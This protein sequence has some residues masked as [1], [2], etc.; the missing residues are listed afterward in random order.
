MNEASEQ[1]S[2]FSTACLAIGFLGLIV[3]ML[4]SPLGGLSSAVRQ[5]AMALLWSGLGGLLVA[6]CLS[7]F[8]L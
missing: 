5:T 6:L 2:T 7:T 1:L 3:S 4:L 8:G